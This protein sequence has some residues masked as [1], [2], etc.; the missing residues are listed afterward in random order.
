[1]IENS[2]NETIKETLTNRLANLLDKLDA[3]ERED[4]MDKNKK[5][6]KDKSMNNQEDYKHLT[7]HNILLKGIINHI[8]V[9]EVYKKNRSVFES[10]SPFSGKLNVILM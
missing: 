7:L 6:D 10:I 8:D 2:T 3:E 5:E 9:F 4:L 1:M